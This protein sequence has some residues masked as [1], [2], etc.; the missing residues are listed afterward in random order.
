MMPN[1]SNLKSHYKQ[2]NNLEETKEEGSV[3]V[4]QGHIS[5][6]FM[7]SLIYIYVLYIVF[8]RDVEIGC[9]SILTKQYF[10]KKYI[11][12]GRIN[13]LCISQPSH[14]TNHKKQQQLKPMRAIFHP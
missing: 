6:F 9:K 1:N 13:A 8:L 4:Y 5:R 7:T 12:Q 14:I 3:I 11:L 2:N 10:K